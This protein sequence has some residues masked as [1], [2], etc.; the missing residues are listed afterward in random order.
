VAWL[1]FQARNLQT[2]PARA[3]F[4]AEQELAPCVSEDV[5]CLEEAAESEPELRQLLGELE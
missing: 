4:R 5:V 2:L 1:R 3:E